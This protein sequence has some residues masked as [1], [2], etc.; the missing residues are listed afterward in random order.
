MQSTDLIQIN[1]IIVAITIIVSWAFF[2]H[3]GRTKYGELYMDAIKPI[4]WKVVKGL[5]PLTLYISICVY[6]GDWNKLKNGVAFS[7]VAVGFFS[8]ALHEVM[9]GFA[10]DRVTPASESRIRVI[11]RG[12]IIFHSISLVTLVMVFMAKEVSYAAVIIQIILALV[13]VI[14]YYLAGTVINLFRV[15]HIPGSFAKTN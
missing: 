12:L 11:S 7:I 2:N 5:A 13:S 8:M 15:G 3:K 1:T 4:M 14:T 6:T 10:V 9:C